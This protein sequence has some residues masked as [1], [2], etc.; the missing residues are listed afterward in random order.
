M[1]SIDLSPVATTLLG[2]GIAGFVA[3]H[4]RLRWVVATQESRFVTWD[5]MKRIDDRFDTI[6]NE[7]TAVRAELQRVAVAL[8]RLEGSVSG[9]QGT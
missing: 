3:D 5:R 7:F 8:A 4:I 6:S 1:I 2:F 9:H